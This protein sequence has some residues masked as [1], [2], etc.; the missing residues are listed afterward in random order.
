[1]PDA[2]YEVNFAYLPPMSGLEA[3]EPR[4]DPG[5]INVRIGEGRTA[6]VLRNLCYLVA[7]GQHGA[8]RWARISEQIS[9][10]FGVNLD[11]PRYVP[12]RGEIEMTYTNRAGRVNNQ[13]H[14]DLSTTGRGLLQTLLLLVYMAANPGAVLLLDEPDAHLEILRQR[15]IYEVLSEAARQYGSQIIAASHSEIVLNEAADRDVVVAFLGKPHR[16]DDRSK[17]QLRKALAKIRFDDYY[18]AEQTGWVLYLEGSTDLAILRSFADTLGH[19]AAQQALT[20]PFVHYLG[21]NRPTEAEEHF[22]GLREAKTDLVGYVL[23]DHVAPSKIQ[24]RPDLREHTWHK[25]EIENYLCQRGTLIAWARSNGG[26][27]ADGWVQAMEQSIA[28]VERLMRLRNDGSPWSDGAKVS[29]DF[30]LPLFR[31]FYERLGLDNEMNKSNFHRLA[32]YVAKGDLD[33]EV[34]LVLDE[35]VALANEANPV[36]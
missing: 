7:N 29:N 23:V 33:P 13:P 24:I 16:I 30:L 35:I 12:G 11:P 26:A 14:L 22:Y 34:G 1:V 9:Y 28:E 32:R 21:G 27:A 2:A 3:N 36:R 25:R 10:M 20:R 6:E 18:L 5:A 19:T 17:Q 31:A 15:E 8:V 4:L